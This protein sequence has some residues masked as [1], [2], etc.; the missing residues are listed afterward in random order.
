MP[1]EG[2]SFRRNC[3]VPPSH[4]Q[5]AGDLEQDYA[6]CWV[7]GH[8]SAWGG[9]WG[10]DVLRAVWNLSIVVSEPGRGQAQRPRRREQ[11]VIQAGPLSV[12]ELSLEGVYS[13]GLG[14]HAWGRSSCFL[15]RMEKG[16][17]ARGT[18]AGCEAGSAHL[19][20]LSCAERATGSHGAGE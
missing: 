19:A 2:D 9:G 16:A 8:C 7:K 6:P 11:R 5:K 3:R 4:S 15:K 1:E 20:G 18:E 10:D 14:R 13:R 17:P 12:L